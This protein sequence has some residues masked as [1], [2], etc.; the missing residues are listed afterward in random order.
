MK[1]QEYT[2]PLNHYEELELS[3]VGDFNTK[4]LALHQAIGAVYARKHAT[5]ICKF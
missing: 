4:M 5:F 1:V 2:L 3:W